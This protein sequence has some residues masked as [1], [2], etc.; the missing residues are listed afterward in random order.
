M[1]ENGRRDILVVDDSATGLDALELALLRIPGAAVHFVADAESALHELEAESYCA[2]ISDIHLPEM[3]GLE[4]LERMRAQLRFRSVPVLILSGDAD[5]E[6]PERAHRLGADAFFRKP[7][8]P[9]AVC[10]KVE[11]LIHAK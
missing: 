10:R 5:P 3:S 7:Y 9:S 1:G 11:E 2:V 6:T 8:S 4:L